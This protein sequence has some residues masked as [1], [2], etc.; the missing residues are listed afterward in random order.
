MQKKEAKEQAIKEG[1]KKMWNEFDIIFIAEHPLLYGFRRGENIEFYEYKDGVYVHIQL[2]DMVDLVDALMVE[3][4]LLALRIS[5]NKVRDTVERIAAT[6]AR[7]HKVMTDE[8]VQKQ[9]WRIN[10]KNGLFNPKTMTLEPHTHEY[11]STVQVPFPYEPEA[12]APLFEQFI[13]KV[14]NNNKDTA[15]MLQEVFGY[16]LMDGNPKHKVFYFYGNTARNGKST[17]AKILSGL[18]GN[19]NVSALSLSQ[20]G[21]DNS[22]ILL[23]LVGKQINFSDEISTK[24]IESPR[25]VSLSSEGVIEVNP[26]YKNTFTCSIRAKFII[27]CNDMPRFQDSQGIRHRLHVIPF[28]V[29]IPQEERIDRYDEVL[30]SKEGSGILNWAIQGLQLFLMT[31]SFTTSSESADIAEDNKLESD[32]LR[33]YLEEYYSF[34]PNYVNHIFPEEI[35]GNEKTREDDATGYRGYCARSGIKTPSIFT[36]N[37]ALVRFADETKKIKQKKEESGKRYYVGLL[38]KAPAAIKTYQ[39]ETQATYDIF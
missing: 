17:T 37:R 35:Y 19:G 39:S 10:L 36:M 16:C 22:S 27:A 30:L 8:K 1:Q 2:R 13:A 5:R 26:K 6:L 31:N 29:Q 25:L 32:P 21:A 11:F 24:Y 9:E 7:M 38:L 4:G 15:R 20:I 23:S 12:T 33:A 28:T 14:S 34:N 3:K 18:I